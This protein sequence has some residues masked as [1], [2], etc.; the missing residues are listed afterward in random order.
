MA[1][2]SSCFAASW[3]RRSS[4]RAC[5]SAVVA[6]AVSRSADMTSSGSVLGSLCRLT[7]QAAH[8]ADQTDAHDMTAVA[9]MRPG[10]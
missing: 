1:R 8:R 5:E 4:N 9:M 7:N 10:A 2:I 6:A 3:S